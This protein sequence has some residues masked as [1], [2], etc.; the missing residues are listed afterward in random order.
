MAGWVALLILSL[1][2]QSIS[3]PLSTVLEHKTITEAGKELGFR[4]FSG[5]PLLH[6]CQL[7]GVPGKDL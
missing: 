5:G 7:W 4:G 6:C 2:A 3:Y 1:L